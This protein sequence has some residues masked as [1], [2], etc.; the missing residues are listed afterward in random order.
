MIFT[1]CT[2]TMVYGALC[3]IRP[4]YAPPS[5][6]V[7][8][9]AQGRL[10]F[11]KNSGFPVDRCAVTIF[12]VISIAFLHLLRL[13]VKRCIDVVQRKRL[14]NMT[15]GVLRAYAFFFNTQSVIELPNLEE[16]SLMRL[17]I[18]L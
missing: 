4:Q 9:G 15:W 6:N 13:G 17:V 8:H 5:R 7:H 1:L 14:R 10:Y 16:N 18:Y 3:T 2:T 12:P 11:L